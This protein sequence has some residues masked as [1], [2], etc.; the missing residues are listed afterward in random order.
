MTKAAV[1]KEII[2]TSKLLKKPVISTFGTAICVVLKFGH[3]G[4]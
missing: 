1:H 3:F 2:Y 4:K